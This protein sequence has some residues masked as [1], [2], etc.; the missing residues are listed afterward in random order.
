[1]F[2][3]AAQGRRGERG[4]EGGKKSS[5]LFHQQDFVLFYLALNSEREKLLWLITEQQLGKTLEGDDT[6]RRVA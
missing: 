1:M 4:K 2:A 3:A 5:L 6:R